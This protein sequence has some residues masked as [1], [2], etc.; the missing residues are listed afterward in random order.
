MVKTLRPDQRLALQYCIKQGNPALFIEMGLGKCLITLRYIQYLDVKNVLIV[1]PYSTFEGWQSELKA[2]GLPPALELNGTREQRYKLLHERSKYYLI[3]KEGFL[4]IPEIEYI[5]CAMLV[6]DESTFVKSPQTQVSKFFTKTYDKNSFPY[7]KYRMILTGTPAP[8]SPL[9]YFQQLYFLNPDILGYKNYWVFRQSCFFEISPGNW[10]MKVDKRA[11]F[12]QRLK[13]NCFYMSRKEAGLDIPKVYEKRLVKFK[14]ETQKLYDKLLNDFILEGYKRTKFEPVK[15]CWL[16]QLC[17][18]YA[19][20][21]LISKEKLTELLSL[22]FGELVGKPVII[23]TQ[24]ICEIKTL[25]EALPGS[26]AV[27]GEISPIKRPEIIKQWQKGSNALIAHPGCFKYGADLG[28]ADIMIYYS[29]PLG[30]ESRLQSEARFTRGVKKE[31]VLIIDLM[32][33]NSIEESILE[34]LQAK[35]TQSD[36]IGRIVENE[37]K[38]RASYIH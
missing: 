13:D 3:N 16:R 10:T 8:E 14:K 34:G 29:S 21:Q 11:W 6:L 23:W 37:R 18:G 2:E 28:H 1:A 24:F 35:Q 25:Q 31:S 27:Y 9:D 26:Y 30:L 7:T 15:F 38:K 4:S 12:H 17:S 33:K 32:I 36:I 5:N 19:D 20:N 22:L